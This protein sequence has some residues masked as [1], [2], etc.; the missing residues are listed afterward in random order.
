MVRE[1]QHHIAFLYY[2]HNAAR[3][4]QQRVYKRLLAG[5]D[6]VEYGRGKIDEVFKVVYPAAGYQVVFFGKP[7]AP[8]EV[9]EQLRFDMPV[10]DKARG[11]APFPVL[12]AFF[13]FVQ[14][15]GVHIIIQLQFCIPGQFDNITQE[16]I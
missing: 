15:V 5:F 12:Q 7:K 13:Q 2:I 9:V 10:E 8:C 3:L 14:Q 4:L 6:I 1:V 11:S 16:G